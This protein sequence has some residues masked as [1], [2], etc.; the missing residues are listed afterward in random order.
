MQINATNNITPIP[1]PLRRAANAAEGRDGADF[2]GAEAVEKTLRRTPE[3]RSEEVERAKSLIKDEKYPPD[4]T[5]QGI[6]NLIA[7]HLYGGRE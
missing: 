3:I 2:S 5:I 4:V 1:E 7:S 6:A